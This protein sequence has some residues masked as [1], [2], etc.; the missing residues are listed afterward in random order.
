VRAIRHGNSIEAGRESD[1]LPLGDC[2]T[3]TKWV[4]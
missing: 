2:V 3:I 4:G 1:S